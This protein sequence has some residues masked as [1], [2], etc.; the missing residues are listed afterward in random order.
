MSELKK[1]ENS[2][3]NGKFIFLNLLSFSF[4]FACLLLFRAPLLF[5]ADHYLSFDEAYQGSQILDLMN[6]GPIQFYYEGESYAGIFLGLAAIPFF[7]LFGVSAF[8]Y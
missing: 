5:N 3:V 2:L 7:W 6:G 4:I 8:S 1:K